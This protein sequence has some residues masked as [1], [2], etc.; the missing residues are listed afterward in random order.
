MS[1][2]LVIIPLLLLAA[3]SDDPQVTALLDRADSLTCEQPD[4]ALRLL[5]QHEAEAATWSRSLRMRHALLTARAQNKTFVDFTT[6]SVL[7]E[8]AAY[9][10][11]HGTPNQ[12]L[13]AHYLL[14]CAY[15]DLDEAPRAIDA[16]QDAIARADTTATDCDY[17]TLGSVYAQMAATFYQQNLIHDYLNYTD[18]SV[19]YGLRSGDTLVAIN[20]Y[21]YKMAAYD[22]MK[23]Y[24][25]VAV[26]CEEVYERLC[27]LGLRKRAAQYL[28]M[29][30]DAFLAQKDTAKARR[31]IIIYEQESGYFDVNG[32]IEEGREA[33]YFSKGNLYLTTHQLDSAEICFR[34][35]LRNKSFM[36]QNM[37]A[38]GLSQVFLQRHQNDSAAKYALYSYSMN[39]S[40]YA[41]MA[42]EEVEQTKGMYSYAT[43][44]REAQLEKERADEERARFR[45]LL[46]II[47]CAIVASGLFVRMLMNRRK[48]EQRKYMEDIYRLER[49]QT[50]LLLLRSFDEENHEKQMKEMEELV[51]KL[52]KEMKWHHEQKERLEDSDVYKSL[53]GKANAGNLL[54]REDW[55]SIHSLVIEMIPDYYKFVSSKQF[56]LNEKEYQTCILLRLGVSLNSAAYMQGVTPAYISKICKAMMVK[57]FS[58]EGNGKKFREMLLNIG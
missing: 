32:N 55:H 14:G 34:K 2:L 46:Y 31:Y 16:F 5:R 28:M 25:S 24:D 30:V 36:N 23:M 22:R 9:Y 12:Q 37:A 4:S 49:A 41:H 20:E 42:T 43:H 45:F 6:D 17:R 47:I 57:F 56:A 50:D 35:E 33:Y 15:R 7:L 39:D 52:K 18:R 58:E 11:R 1:R 38:Y 54:T 29:G 53:H 19:Y 21:A 27:L 8:V 51:S 44:Q 13:E 10:D 26:V 40:V 48:A 3:C